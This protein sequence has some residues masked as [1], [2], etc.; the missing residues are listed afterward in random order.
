MKRVLPAI[1]A[2][3]IVASPVLAAE[4]SWDG[5]LCEMGHWI[6]Q[7]SAI[8]AINGLNLSREQA[9]A[10]RDLARRMEAVSKPPEMK[11]ELY[12]DFAKV[13][14][15]YQELRQV[16]LEGREV[17]QELQ[18]KVADA[19]R[20]ES[21][22]IRASLTAPSEAKTGCARCHAPPEKFEPAMARG[23]LVDIPLSRPDFF[24]SPTA[25]R[26]STDWAH[27]NGE[28]GGLRG[29]WTLSRLAQDVDATLTESQKEIVDTF[30]C[31]L[32]PPQELSDPVRAGQ[33]DASA[34]ELELLRKVRKV[35]DPTWRRVKE[36][37]VNYLNRLVDIK[38][39]GRSQA[40]VQADRRRVSDLFEKVR[41]ASD[42]EFEMSKEAFCKE[43]KGNRAQEDL[44]DRK[45]RF[46]FAYFLLNPGTSD[47]Y[48][49]IVKRMDAQG[50]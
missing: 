4:L 16:L 31:C 26:K 39:P 7:I 43:L 42:T 14:E 38:S 23:D 34:K 25:G 5:Q 33:A 46:K 9:M 35:P 44:P 13:R 21:A 40:Q 45:R 29:I 49:A 27:L 12:G 18:T 17:P 1:L 8:N 28:L 10:L 6:L 30:A 32:I 3:A 47:V 37:W 48:D 41:A 19:R 22:I 20:M 36:T 50:K 15:T 11:G 24:A 2:C